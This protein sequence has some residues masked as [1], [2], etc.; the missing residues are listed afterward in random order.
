MTNLWQLRKLSTNE[1]LSEPQPLPENWGPIFGLHNF[2]D[3]LGD[4]SWLQNPELNDMGWFET[5]IPVTVAKI[6]DNDVADTIKTLLADSDWAMMPDVPMTNG[7]KTEWIEYRRAL[8]EIKNQA[9]YPNDI[10]WPVKP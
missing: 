2:V 6:T 3:K 1:N 9:G 4:L 7:K 10:K 5:G 8:R